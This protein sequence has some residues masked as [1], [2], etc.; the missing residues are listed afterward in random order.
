MK[1]QI[2]KVSK[3][4]KPNRRALNIIILVVFLLVILLLLPSHEDRMKKYLFDG[5]DSTNSSIIKTEKF[6]EDTEKRLE[7]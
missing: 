3:Y 1:S 4:L 5:I 2:L 6:I 7:E